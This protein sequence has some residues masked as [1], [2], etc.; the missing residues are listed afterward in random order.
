[1]GYVAK[2]KHGSRTLDLS[3]GRYG[4]SE[5]FVP[6]SV[7]M[8]VNYAGGTSAN[9]LSGSSRVSDRAE[10]R[11]WSFGL[12]IR[13]ESMAEIRRAVDDVQSFLSWA[14]D[15]ND[16]V[17]FHWNTSDVVPTPSWGQDGSLLYEIVDGVVSLPGE[18]YYSIAA[19]N[20]QGL[21]FCTVTLTVKPFAVGLPQTLAQAKGAI[22]HDTVGTTGGR[23]RG[24]VV[25]YPTTNVMTNPIHAHSTW[26]TGW[27]ASANMVA[28]ENSDPR[29]IPEGYGIRSAK[30]QAKGASADWYQSP[31]LTASTYTISCYVKR[32]DGGVVDSTVVQLIHNSIAR[33]TTY[34]AV[35]DGWYRLR[36]SGTGA[37]AVASYG[38][39]LAGIAT[40]LYASAWKLENVGYA[41]PVTHGDMAGCAWSST[42]HSSTTTVTT[43][44]LRL[45]ISDDWFNKGAGCIRAVVTIPDSSY[46]SNLVIFYDGASGFRGY[47]D[48][49]GSVWFNDGTNS[50]NGSAP[51][52]AGVS[53]VFHWVWDQGRIQIYVNGSSVASGGTHTV[54]ASYNHLYIG[55]DNTP[56]LHQNQVFGDFTVWKEPLRSAQ[57]LADYTNIAPIVADGQRVNPIPYLWDKDGDST[58]D[59]Y[60]DTSNDNWVVLRNIPGSAPAKTVY[61]LTTSGSATLSDARL[62][63][64]STREFINPGRVLYSEQSGTADGTCSGSAYKRTLIGTAE[65]AANASN[66]TWASDPKLYRFVQGREWFAVARMR[67]ASGSGKARQLLFLSANDSVSGRQYGQIFVPYFRDTLVPSIVFP[68]LDYNRLSFASVA[69]YVAATNSA[70]IN[71]DLDFYCLFPRPLATFS[72]GTKTTIDGYRWMTEFYDTFGVGGYSK[73]GNTGDDLSL[74]PDAHNVLLY[75]AYGRLSAVIDNNGVDTITFSKV[76][77]T[78]RYSLL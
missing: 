7:Q 54:Q 64:W 57:V 63:L 19:L 44:F 60:D 22:T 72:I 6:P 17:F 2:I 25:G 34:T 18:N 58:V 77:V 11:T 70:N 55:S 8:T 74:V 42:V 69:H 10:N 9:R 14:G 59:T 62:G 4:V 5:D 75:S 50:I 65:T 46:G 30:L 49:G 43:P 32:P 29:Y 37:A 41:T 1:M 35:G 21:P 31:T 68:V 45:P 40:T 47:L 3:S 16:P 53:Y 56:A 52:T 71:T 76:T 23:D 66:I 73:A 67:L 36:Y 78:P 27:S 51:I 24:I 15:D 26:S 48:T 39:R 38:L 20:R 33:T 13:G 12:H 28:T 61:E